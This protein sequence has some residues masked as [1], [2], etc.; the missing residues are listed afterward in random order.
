MIIIYYLMIIGDGWIGW[1]FYYL[2]SRLP[3]G[4]NTGS[5]SASRNEAIQAW[6]KIYGRNFPRVKH[7]NYQ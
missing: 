5:I 3:K 1:I 4:E 2:S 6:R 7:A